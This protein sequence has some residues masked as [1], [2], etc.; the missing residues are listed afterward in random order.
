VTTEQSDEG[1]EDEALA[2]RNQVSLRI[3]RALFFIFVVGGVVVTSAMHSPARHTLPLVAVI[4]ASVAAI[5]AFTGRPSGA[6]RGWIIV[7]PSL[8]VTIAG[9]L[10]VGML[11]GPG[12]C[13]T[14]A[15]MLS[16]L[17]LG[18]RVMLGLT[19]LSA[20][21]V[22]AIAWAMVHGRIPAPNP[23]DVSMTNGVAWMRTLGV[24]FLAMSLFGGFM[25]A[26]V[27]RIEGALRLARFETRRREQAERAR[28]EAEIMALES[29]QLEMIGRLAAGV[30]HDFNN[31]LTAIMGSAEL[32][33][34]ELREK[35]GSSDLA[36]GILQASQRVAE[37]TRQLLAYSRRAQ[38]LLKPADLHRLV[39]DAVSLVRRSS[40]PSLQIVTRLDAP[41]AVIAADAA[42]MESALLNLFVNAREA[43]PAGGTL[44]IETSAVEG[45][46]GSEPCGPWVLVK[47]KDSGPGIARELLP[48]IFDPFF[49][50]KPVG[51]G[52]GLG[53]AAVSGTV[54]AHG[55]RI[56]VE[57]ELGRGSTFSVYL[58]RSKTDSKEPPAAGSDIVR[59]SGQILLVEDDRMVA[60][61]AISTLKSFGYDVS[62]APDGKSALALVAAGGTR[63]SLVLLDLRMP[64]MSGEATF[65]ALRTLDSGLKV[66]IWS[67]YGA[68]QDVQSMLDRGAVGFVAKPYRVADLSR[69]IA[70]ALTA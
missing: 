61:T 50:T 8:F 51:R 40:D 36:D 12:V 68:E 62:H 56:E 25:L 15:L 24:T 69:A 43:M 54:R 20:L 53:L 49:T 18:R 35:G 26:V 41:N 70:R 3:L 45:S 65:E 28:A 11:S 57:S 14:L 60:L 5:P 6:L 59:G 29:K 48:H 33:R 10:F 58:P 17:L 63:F 21:V 2:W 44:T 55:G 42:L 9:Y 1:G 19:A 4:G 22:A 7:L 13:L 67:G 47:V 27:A 39:N 66:L 52:T 16:G 30:A 46:S 37:L 32:L 23:H 31:N 34:D 64:G 38:M